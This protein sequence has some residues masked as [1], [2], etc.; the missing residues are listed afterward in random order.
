MQ[1]GKSGKSDPYG[2]YEKTPAHDHLADADADCAR[3]FF[4]KLSPTFSPDYLI[5][6]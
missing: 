3:R 6:Q 1:V 4:S 2:T 5:H